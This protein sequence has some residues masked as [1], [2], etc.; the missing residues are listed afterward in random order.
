MLRMWERVYRV[1]RVSLI[2]ILSAGAPAWAVA[3]TPAPAPDETLQRAVGVYE[4]V[5][6]S[7]IA[8]GGQKLAQE[9]KRIAPSV[10]LITDPPVIR[11]FRVPGGL[12]F[13]VQAPNISITSTVIDMMSRL[14]PSPAMRQAGPRVIANGGIVEPDPMTVA[15]GPR[16]DPD[17]MYSTY[18]REALIDAVLDGSSVLNLKD[19]EFLTVSASGMDEPYSNTLYRDRKLILSISGAQLSAYRQMRITREQAKEKIA[20]DR[21]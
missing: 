12:H 2:G 3:Q 4:G 7:A 10:V 9:T 1:S 15:P 17:A 8:Q 21:W 5:L 13:D 20:E 16:F 19:D 14:Q 11:S 18:V 6:R